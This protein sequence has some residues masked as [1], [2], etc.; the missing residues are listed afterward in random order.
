MLVK[1]Q[2]LSEEQMQLKTTNALEPQE[3]RIAEIRDTLEALAEEH[4][5]GPKNQA[6]FEHLQ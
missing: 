5:G 2:K 4:R 3:N 1:L 6:R